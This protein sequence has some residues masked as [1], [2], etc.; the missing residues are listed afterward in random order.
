MITNPKAH[1]QSL[2]F[3]FTLTKFFIVKIEWGLPSIQGWRS[4]PFSVLSSRLII[5]L[6][7]SLVRSQSVLRSMYSAYAQER[8]PNT[9]V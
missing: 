2:N 4:F 7:A 5:V 6:M 3:Y 1:M 9:Q 8:G